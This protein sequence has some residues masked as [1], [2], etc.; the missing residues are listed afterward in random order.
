M[1]CPNC[2]EAARRPEWPGYTAACKGCAARGIANGPEF[3]R[4][5]KDG[6]LT[7]SYTSAL[8]SIWGED[9][10][11]GHE[12]VKAAAEKLRQARETVL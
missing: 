3:H 6:S 4:S 7:P 9:W 11:A 5:R 10:R 1:T 8:Y 12:A 2:T